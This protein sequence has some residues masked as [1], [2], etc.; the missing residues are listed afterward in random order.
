MAR[1][2]GAHVKVIKSWV[3]LGFVGFSWFSWVFLSFLGFSWVFSGFTWVL[4]GFLR[5]SWVFLGFRVFT[6]VFLCFSWVL[7]GFLGFSW[8]LFLLAILHSSVCLIPLDAEL[9]HPLPQWGLP[10]GSGVPA[11][12]LA[13][14]GSCMC[15]FHFVKIEEIRIRGKTTG[16]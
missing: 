4:L 8:V 14:R 2:L 12:A 5:F 7:L 1:P 10:A 11:Q 3:F 6:W 16:C 15:A 13:L 9:G